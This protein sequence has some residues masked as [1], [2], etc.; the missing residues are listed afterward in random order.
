ME[1]FRLTASYVKLGVPVPGDILD[2]QG[3][4]LLSKGHVIK[5]QDALDRLLSRG[6]YVDLKTLEAQFKPQASATAPTA[7]NRY[8][9]FAVH[10]SLKLRLNR[11]LRAVVE[12][13]GSAAEILELAGAIVA[14]AHRDAEAAIAA[15]LLDR[16]EEV[17]PVGHSLNAAVLCAAIARR[18]GWADDRLTATVCA[19]MTMNAGMLEYHQRLHR[20]ATPLAAA[21]VEVLHRHAAVSVSLLEEIGI[22]DAV[23]LGAVRE[24]H[25]KPGGAGYP[26]GN[27]APSESSQLL[28]IADV[29]DARTQL[30]GDRKALAPAQVI[31]HLFADEGK[32]SG[33]VFANALVQVFGLY[34]PGSLVRLANG[35][36]AVVFRHGEGPG[37]PVVAAVTTGAGTPV[38][39][40]VRRETH[41][42]GLSVV[43]TLVPE[44]FAFG[45]DLGKL[46]ISRS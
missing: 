34:P 12:K 46:W 26:A 23:W 17:Y 31:R 30:R 5:E 11:V 35:E 29:F 24:H 39:Q 10:A 13:T 45:Y 21:Q 43:G 8:D 44:R 16:H 3:H 32:G 28:R 38:M 1:M 7:E 2:D 41:R 9:P 42:L 22:V 20:Q 14:H 18:L 15:S 6:M 19:A 40:P 4:M 27:P 37:T 25:E 36:Q 33:A